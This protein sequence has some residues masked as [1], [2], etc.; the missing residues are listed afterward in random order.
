MGAE[1]RI[2]AAGFT[3]PAPAAPLGA[4][5]PAV[6]AGPFVYT[7]GHL[8][9]EA[10]SLAE[11]FIGKVGAT[12]S[13]ETAREAAARCAA[14]ALAA[15]KALVGDL[16]RVERVVKVTGF[17]ASAPDF[18]AQPE[19]INAASD[20]LQTAFGEAGRH[21]RSAIGVAALPRDACVEV[22]VIVQLR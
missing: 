5:V 3:L 10:G 14:N 9:L 2:A 15:V 16:E 18:T 6:Q 7:S 8:P 11:R 4:Y 13:T 12:V 21:A 22:E 20:L 17:V 1:E 19:V